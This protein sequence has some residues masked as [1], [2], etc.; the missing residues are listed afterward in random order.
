MNVDIH[1]RRPGFPSVFVTKSFYGQIEYILQVTLPPAARLNPGDLALQSQSTY[2]LACIHSCKVDDAIT[3]SMQMPL[4]SMMGS[5][6]AVDIS[7]VKCLVGRVKNGKHT[8][9]LDRTA[10]VQQSAHFRED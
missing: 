4:Y 7:T 2:F 6:E 10:Q 3:N 5:K 9:I 8:V 1:A